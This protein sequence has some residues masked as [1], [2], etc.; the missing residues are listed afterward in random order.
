MPNEYSLACYVAYMWSAGG[1][2]PYFKISTKRFWRA[3]HTICPGKPTRKYL[4]RRDTPCP[5]RCFSRILI[6]LGTKTHDWHRKRN[7][8]RARSGHIQ[9]QCIK[10]WLVWKLA[11]IHPFLVAAQELSAALKHQGCSRSPLI[12]CG[13]IL[14]NHYTL[15]AD[16]LMQFCVS[17]SQL[18]QKNLRLN[19]SC[20]CMQWN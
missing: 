6:I 14:S 19:K 7:L 3:S 17:K 11:S 15:L 16:L 9:L 13:S 8:Y 2:Q 20:T 12:S 18:L 5:C 4:Y 10:V 1:K